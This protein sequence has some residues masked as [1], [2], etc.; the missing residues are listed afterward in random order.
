MLR[1][2]LYPEN[3]ISYPGCFD[4]YIIQVIPVASLIPQSKPAPVVQIL[5]LRPSEAR[6]CPG[7]TLGSIEERLNEGEEATFIYYA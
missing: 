7:W 4:S 1:K 2:Y 3:P 6:L 5:H